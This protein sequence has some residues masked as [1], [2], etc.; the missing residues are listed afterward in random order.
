MIKDRFNIDIQ[1]DEKDSVDLI[2]FKS[3]LVI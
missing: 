3:I 2:Y 1:L